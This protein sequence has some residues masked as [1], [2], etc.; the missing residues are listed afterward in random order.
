MHPEL[1]VHNR[2]LA[3]LSERDRDLVA[4]YF[5]PVDYTVGQLLVLPKQPVR[6]AYFPLGGLISILAVT[7]DRRYFEIGMYGNEGMG[8]ISIVLG[9]DRT[10]N[11]HKVQADGTALR[12]ARS[13][14]E[15][16]MARSPE[17]RALLLHYADA[18]AV[19][20]GYTALSNGSADVG[21]RLARWLLMYQD[22]LDS[23]DL[24]L[25]H[26]VLGVM[27]GVPLS[28]VADAISL[29]EVPGV[30]ETGQGHI[31]VVHRT[32]LEKAA[33]ESYGVPEAEY[34]RLIGFMEGSS[35]KLR[36]SR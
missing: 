8:P 7:T 10:P 30:I 36:T 25:T 6:Y 11:E 19:Q 29:L 3:V 33:G 14:L 1:L 15:N 23:D 5:E 16:T 31:R 24:P 27:L 28:E 9:D 35:T 17:L 21:E 2:L 4:P 22:R 12:I 13:A 34:A 32:S 20:V 26:E 18:F